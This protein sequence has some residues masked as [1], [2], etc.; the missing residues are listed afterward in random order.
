MLTANSAAILTDAFPLKQRGM[1]L[2]VNQIAG[3]A[4][5]FLGLLAGGQLAIVDWRAV[6]WINV[7]IGI[8]GTLWSYRSLR[9][10]G[11][12]RRARID[13]AGNITFTLGVGAILVAITHGIQPYGGNA[14]GW[15]NPVVLGGLA[16]G[17]VLLI[18][19]AV[20]ETHIA[21]PMFNLA[22]FRIRA[23]AAGRVAALLVSTARGGLA[24]HADHLVARNLVA[25]ARI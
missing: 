4:G 8:A 25:P 23:F 10:N 17:V 14:T 6:F 9:D 15:S 7:P 16:A 20:I 22:L 1:A 11:E 18:A 3:L 13:W 2:G 12:R 19:F 21:E 5:Q 24:V